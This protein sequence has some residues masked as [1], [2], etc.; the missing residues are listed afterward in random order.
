MIG[1]T[2]L[3]IVPRDIA[4]GEYAHA[5]RGDEKIQPGHGSLALNL[6]AEE[7]VSCPFLQ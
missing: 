7:T 4:V 5:T 1:G 2:Y 3:I 6:P